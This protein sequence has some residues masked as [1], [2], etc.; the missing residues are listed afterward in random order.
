MISGGSL[1]MGFSPESEA[2]CSS[3]SIA[4]TFHQHKPVK[5]CKKIGDYI[6]KATNHTK[7]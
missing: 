4:N 6:E 1:V 2:V 5:P 3:I 7:I